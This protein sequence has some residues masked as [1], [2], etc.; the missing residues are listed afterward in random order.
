MSPDELE[1]ELLLAMLQENR[2]SGETHFDLV[3]LGNANGFG[4]SLRDVIFFAEENDGLLGKAITGGT[5]AEFII[6]ANGLRRAKEIE[7]TR[8]SPTIS[9]RIK[10][11]PIG[12][13]AWDVF[14]IGLGVILGVIATKYFG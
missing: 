9:Q 14:K 3:E 2:S 4:Q 13:G 1:E 7:E 11:I 5:F 12:K 8:R 6:N 10:A